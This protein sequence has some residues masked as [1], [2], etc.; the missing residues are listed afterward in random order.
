MKQHETQGMF[1]GQHQARTR[2]ASGRA[3]WRG[4]YYEGFAPAE[5]SALPTLGS[6]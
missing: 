4:Q 1:A 3:T 2:R 5:S 6:V